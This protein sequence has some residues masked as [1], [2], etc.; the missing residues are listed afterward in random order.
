MIIINASPLSFLALMG[1]AKVGKTFYEGGGD[2]QDTHYVR[3][4]REDA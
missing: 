1:K 2:D 3:L 4:V